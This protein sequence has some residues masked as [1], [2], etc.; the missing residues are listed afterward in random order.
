MERLDGI[1]DER[2][3]IYCIN[4]TLGTTYYSDFCFF[5]SVPYHINEMCKQGKG[6]IKC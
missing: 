3:R 1:S 6:E 4:D 2:F 5:G